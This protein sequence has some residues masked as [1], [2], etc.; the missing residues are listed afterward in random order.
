PLPLNDLER[1]RC[2]VSDIPPLHL[3]GFYSSS[4]QGRDFDFRDHPLLYEYSRGVMACPHTQ[5]YLRGDLDLLAE[6]PPKELPGLDARCR[7][8]ENRASR[9]MEG[10]NGGLGR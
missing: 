7:P 8:M 4:L 1:I 10:I 5:D 9:I 6:F 2:F 3:L